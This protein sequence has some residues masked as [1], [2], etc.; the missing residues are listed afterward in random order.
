[1]PSHVHSNEFLLKSFTEWTVVG[2]KR[3]YTAGER[4]SGWDFFVPEAYNQ[5]KTRKLQVLYSTDYNTLHWRTSFRI[6]K[7]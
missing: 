1:M 5:F 3:R 6:H 7:M 4:E 2:K